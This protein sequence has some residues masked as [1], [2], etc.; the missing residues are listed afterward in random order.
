MHAQPSALP[1]GSICSKSDH[2][3][4]AVVD[5]PVLYVEIFNFSETKALYYLTRPNLHEHD[6]IQI[7]AVVPDTRL[8]GDALL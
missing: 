3:W 5:G 4:G 7:L 1:I 2:S 6:L 8:A